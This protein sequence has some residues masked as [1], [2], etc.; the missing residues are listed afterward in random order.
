MKIAMIGQ[1]QI[2]SRVGGIEVAVEALSV[3]MAAKGH[4]VTLYNRRRSHKGKR[5]E[6]QYRWN[7]RGVHI[8]EVPVIDIRGVSAMMGSLFATIAAVL[9]DWDV[10]EKIEITVCTP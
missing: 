9:A 3:R 6:K 5:E 2:P 7:Y 10:V 1:K 8:C 4:N